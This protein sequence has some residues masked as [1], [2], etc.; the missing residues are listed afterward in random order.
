MIRSGRYSG[1]DFRDVRCLVVD[2][3]QFSRRAASRI[4][5]NLGCREV[6]TAADGMEALDLML[7]AAHSYDAII[8]DF[9]MPKMDGLELLKMVRTGVRGVARGTSVIMVTSHSEKH[10]VGAA[11]NL[12]VDYFILKPVTVNGLKKRLSRLLMTDRPV[13][14][15]IDYETISI[16][17]GD[18]L[19]RLA[20]AHIDEA[21]GLTDPGLGRGSEFK[22]LGAIQPNDKLAQD[23]YAPGGQL[24]V[25]KGHILSERLVDRLRDL[26]EL[27]V[28]LNQILVDSSV[29]C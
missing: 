24:L 10:L 27:G 29:E 6:A 9:E 26:A 22:D 11:F 7:T 5:R 13:K 3:E 12:D 15:P 20:D 17:L 14:D 18:T 8:S 1:M 21:I 25:A 4:L 23:L 2:D 19:E 28:G 16:K